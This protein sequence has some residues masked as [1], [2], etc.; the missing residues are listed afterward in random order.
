ML[1]LINQVN[2]PYNLRKDLKFLPC[3]R[4][5]AFMVPRRYHI[6]KKKSETWILLK[7]NTLKQ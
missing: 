6:S 2:S 1:E 7:M 3:N 5:N 4:R